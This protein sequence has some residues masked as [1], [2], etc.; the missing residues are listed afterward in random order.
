M[1][2]WDKFPSC[3]LKDEIPLKKLLL[4][5]SKMAKGQNIVVCIQI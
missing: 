4:F 5:I 1:E 2:R 3:H